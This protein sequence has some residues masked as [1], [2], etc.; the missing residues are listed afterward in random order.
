MT[1]EILGKYKDVPPSLPGLDGAT[2]ELIGT[3]KYLHVHTYDVCI[4]PITTT[5]P[6]KLL[7]P[8]AAIG[9]DQ[10]GQ[11]RASDDAPRKQFPETLPSPRSQGSSQ[12]DL[13]QQRK[14]SRPLRCLVKNRSRK[15]NSPSRTPYTGSIA[16][17]VVAQKNKYNTQHR[18]LFQFGG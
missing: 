14:P 3:L 4:F 18:R 11:Q 12:R 13:A 10:G 17:F 15:E 8:V 5:Q 2:A 1:V 6:G 9:R 16:T 7:P